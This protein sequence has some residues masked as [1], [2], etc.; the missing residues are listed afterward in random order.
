[1]SIPKDEFQLLSLIDK[2]KL[3]GHIAIIMDGNGR[4]AKGK[5]LPRVA[6]HRAGMKTVKRIVKLCGELGIKVLTL[7]AFS[8]ENWTRPQKEV[9][10][11]MNLLR[12]YLRKETGELNRDNVKLNFIGRIEQLS[13]LIIKDLKW[14][15]E[16]T[17]HNT[18]LILNIA[19][20]YSGRAD[21]IDAIKKLTADIENKKCSSEDINEPLFEKYLSTA[22]L[23]E[24]DLLI[25]TSGEMRIS[26]FLLWQIAYTEIYITPAYWPDFSRKHFLSA[27]VDYQKRERRFGGILEMKK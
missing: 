11:L 25:R 12:E 13:D 3:P 15:T 24:P 14:A 2:D 23:P 4:W 22:N 9:N 20:N 7:Y 18:G 19:L 8:T 1:M 10:T 26:N 21:I 16:K 17:A 5:K 6:G 27:I